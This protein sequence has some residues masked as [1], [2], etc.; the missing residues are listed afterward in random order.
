[1]VNFLAKV[2]KLRH[3]EF[4]SGAL[5]IYESASLLEIQFD[6]NGKCLEIESEDIA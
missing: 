3:E 2:N 6:L 4:D 5:F 1:M